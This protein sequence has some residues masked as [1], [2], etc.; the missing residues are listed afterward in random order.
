M[1]DNQQLN[2]DFLFTHYKIM[3]GLPNTKLV[4]T[5]NL[6]QPKILKAF[7]SKS[8]ALK[9]V[10][11]N[12]AKKLPCLLLKPSLIAPKVVSTTVI[13][14]ALNWLLKQPITEDE[15]DFLQ[16][17]VLAIKVT[18]VPLTVYITLNGNQQ[19]DVQMK[20]PEQVNVTFSGDALSFVQLFAGDKD[21]DTLFFQRKLLIE[22][23]TEMG[24]MIKNFFDD[25][26]L[27]LPPWLHQQLLQYSQLTS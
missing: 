24:L 16:G 9:P 15:L 8:E 19:I 23:D 11:I 20:E 12:I 25:V 22:G 21:P 4:M 7:A 2:R 26:E 27:T 14:S 3:F 13:G 1:L 18:D 10:T 6:P 5:M 17:Q